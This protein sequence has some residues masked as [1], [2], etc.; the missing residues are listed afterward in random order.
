MVLTYDPKKFLVILG[1]RQIQGYAEDDM[2]TI[3]PLGEGMQ[4]FSGA[5]GEV[6]RSVDPNSAFEITLALSTASK[7]NDYLSAL[8]NADRKNGTGVLPLIIK[9]LAGSTVF[10]APQAWVQN[11]PENKRG[12][13]IDTQ[14]W[15][16]NTGQVAGPIIGGNN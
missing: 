8:Y 14:E 6:A 4:L 12:R 5:D 15:T 11:F 16:L 7:S 10:F 13:K 3:K 1:A 9:D 2:V